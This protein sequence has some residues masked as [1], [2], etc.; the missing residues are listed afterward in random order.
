MRPF[1]KCHT[2]VYVFIPSPVRERF[3]FFGDYRCS[4]LLKRTET[5]QEG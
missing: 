3:V 5:S 2:C 1:V 4:I